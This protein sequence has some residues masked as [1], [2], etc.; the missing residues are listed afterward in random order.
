MFTCLLVHLELSGC[1]EVL[2]LPTVLRLALCLE[3]HL[4]FTLRG[5]QHNLILAQS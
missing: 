5:M 3:S 1:F 2:S 4:L